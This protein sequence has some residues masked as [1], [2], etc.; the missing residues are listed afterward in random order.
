MDGYFSTLPPFSGSKWS[1]TLLLQ[2]KSC[3]SE[4][5]WKTFGNSY[6]PVC[7]F[8]SFVCLSFIHSQSGFFYLLV[9]GVKVV[10]APDRTQGHTDTTPCSTLLD[11]WSARRR[12]LY[13]AT[14]N[15]RKSQTFMR[16]AGFEPAIPAIKRPQT[17]ACI[18]DHIFNV[19]VYFILRLKNT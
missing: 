2:Y 7:L 1:P 18:V 17:I 6:R 4:I 13:L 12:D 10:F 9:V 16:L 11:E 8:I 14:H 15:V 5:C 3:I 19:S